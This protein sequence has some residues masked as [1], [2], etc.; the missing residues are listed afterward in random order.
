MDVDQLLLYLLVVGLMITPIY[1]P[2]SLILP[3]WRYQNELLDN[4]IVSCVV[5][6]L[7]WDKREDKHTRTFPPTSLTE[8]LVHMIDGVK[9]MC[10]RSVFEDCEWMQTCLSEDVPKSE[11]KLLN[12]WYIQNS[13]RLSNLDSA[14]M[15]C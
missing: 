11:K 9:T 1:N 2:N 10:K 14:R 15:V 6:R 3:K 4:W 12:Y 8:K 7:G 13:F 5:K